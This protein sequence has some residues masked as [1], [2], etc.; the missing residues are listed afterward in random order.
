MG[1]LSGIESPAAL[2]IVCESLEKGLLQ[3][4]ALVETWSYPTPALV[5]LGI[6]NP[7]RPSPVRRDPQP[8]RFLPWVERL[9]FLESQ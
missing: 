9:R 5:A 2:M 1:I 6:S 4:G 3:A 8:P 7:G